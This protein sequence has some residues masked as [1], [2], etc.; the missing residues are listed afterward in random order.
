MYRFLYRAGSPAYYL[1]RPADTWRDAL[2]ADRR[3]MTHRTHART[4]RNV[5]D[6]GADTK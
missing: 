2:R 3:R 1:G 6:R 4:R 5:D